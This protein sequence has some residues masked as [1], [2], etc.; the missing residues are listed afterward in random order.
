MM[1]GI[2]ED[3][4]VSL[5]TAQFDAFELTPRIYLINTQ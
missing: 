5:S 4:F 1:P 3:L 2:R